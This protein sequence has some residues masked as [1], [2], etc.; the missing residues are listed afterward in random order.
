M[1]DIFTL[2]D[3]PP[4]LSREQLVVFALSLHQGKM[5]AFLDQAAVFQ[6]VVCDGSTGQTEGNK[7]GSF[8]AAQ[9]QL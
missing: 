1:R 3:V 5:G 6:H 7:D 4:C 8:E 2:S 9:G